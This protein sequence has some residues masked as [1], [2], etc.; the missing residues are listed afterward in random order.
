MHRKSIAVLLIIAL[1]RL[2]AQEMPI[3]FNEKLFYQLSKNQSV[4]LSSLGAQKSMIE[5]QK[6]SYEKIQ[7]QLGQIVAIEAYLHS[8]LSNVESVFK[9]GK[10]FKQLE[11]NLSNLPRLTGQLMELSIKK[12]QY[13]VLLYEFYSAAVIESLKLKNELLEVLKEDPKFLLSAYDRQ[14]LLEKLLYRSRA[15]EGYLYYLIVRLKSLP[16]APYI[17]GI[18]V[19]GGYINQDR[20][21]VKDLLSSSR[22]KWN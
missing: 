17:E 20:R 9:Q 12:P 21:I 13:A 14:L 16:K 8:K 2:K 3:V 10:Q 1:A 5:M 11:R 15:L 7:E 18:P 6:K 19:L 22:F 4:R